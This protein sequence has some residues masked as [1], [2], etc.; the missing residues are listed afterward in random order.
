MQYAFRQPAYFDNNAKW[1]NCR[2][3]NTVGLTM[4]I[5]RKNFY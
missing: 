3:K 5:M 1:R 2:Y 4:R